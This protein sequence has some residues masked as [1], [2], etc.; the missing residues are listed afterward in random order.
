M[1]VQLS[2]PGV[3]IEEFAPGAPIEGVGTSTAAFIGTALSGPIKQPRLVESWDEFVAVFGDIAVEPPASYLAPAVYGFFLNGGT[4]CYVVRAANGA[5]ATAKLA[6]RQQGGNPDPALLATARSEGLAGNSLTVQIKDSSRLASR[7]QAAGVATGSLKLLTAQTTISAISQRTALTVADTTGFA[8]RDRILLSENANANA[9]TAQ[10]V[11]DQVIGPDQLVL[12]APLPGNTVYTLVRIDNL[13]AGQRELRLAVP[14]GLSLSQSLPRGSQI[15]LVGS[16]GTKYHTVESSGGDTLRLTEALANA[17]RMDGATNAPSVSSLE[18]SATVTDTSTAEKEEFP[19]LAMHPD[20]PSYWGNT[21]SSALVTLG[22][23]TALPNPLPDDPR[24][25]ANTYPLASGTPDD[26]GAAWAGILADPNGYLDLLKPYDEIAL[27]AIPGATDKAV[28][29]AIIAHCEATR[30]R[31]GILDSELKADGTAILKQRDNVTSE[32]GFAALYYPWI[33]TR[34]PRTGRN[35]TQ[36]PSG[37][38]AGCFART[39]AERGVFKAPANTNLRGVTDLEQRLTDQQQGRLNLKGVNVLR[40][41]PG[42]GQPLI[43]GA[44]T[45]AS[46]KNWLYV[47]IRRLFLFLEE[48]IQ[49]GIRWAVFEPNDLALWQKLKRSIGAFLTQQWRDGALF[50]ATVEEAFYVRID[51]VLNPDSSRALGRLYIEIGVRPAYPAEFIVVR[52]GI[53]QGG[54]DVSEG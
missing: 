2:Y 33:V 20:H 15:S 10:A 35:E 38:I 1:A 21:F 26:R 30:D 13:A 39:D 44:R 52:I 24:P 27:V 50:G 17:H 3:Y 45:T 42:A 25:A 16:G 18:F 46:N 48:S 28:Q 14:P 40:V 6:S 8:P 34:N 36:P 29:Q 12:R 5:A 19:E 7:L 23:P 47:N 9:L 51:E 31:F 49:E 54:S 11:V 41:L 4:T 53:W 43:W 22:L 32:L 37:H